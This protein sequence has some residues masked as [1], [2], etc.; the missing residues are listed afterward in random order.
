MLSRLNN[1][2]EK[3]GIAI[4]A[5]GWIGVGLVVLAYFL[6][7]FDVMSGSGGLYQIMNLVG[8]LGIIVHSVAR[9]DYQPVVL[10]IIWGLIAV[11]ALLHLVK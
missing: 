2:G 8:A 11:L 5:I 9:K 6:V 10:N 3:P 4:E 7:S 1:S